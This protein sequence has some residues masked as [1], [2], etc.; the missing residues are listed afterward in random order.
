MGDSVLNLWRDDGTMSISI[1]W[2]VAW[3]F[4]TA[5]PRSYVYLYLLTSQ[6]NS[7]FSYLSS[8]LSACTG[9]SKAPVLFIASAFHH[10]CLMAAESS[11]SRRP[12][13]TLTARG[14]REIEHLMHGSPC[15][16]S[17]LLIYS[18]ICNAAEISGML[19]RDPS[20]PPTPPGLFST[21]H[22]HGKEGIPCAAGIE[23][24]RPAKTSIIPSASCPM[25][26]TFSNY[27][28]FEIAIK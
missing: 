12:V 19:F 1:P 16:L 26:Q 4:P 3:M 10:L 14:R 9:L 6:M 28:D 20:P 21:P 23:A 27:S 18:K 24:F 15:I 22:S 7:M 25:H 8:P 5:V 2:Y 13:G 11:S 17:D